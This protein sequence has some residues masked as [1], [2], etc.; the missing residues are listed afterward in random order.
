MKAQIGEVF[1]EDDVVA[2]WVPQLEV[3]KRGFLEEKAQA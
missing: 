2:A 3:R 1:F